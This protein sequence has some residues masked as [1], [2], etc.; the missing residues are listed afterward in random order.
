[1][2][3]QLIVV[4]CIADILLQRYEN[5]RLNMSE[6]NLLHNISIIIALTK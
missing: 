6:N 2:N 3:I 5:N 4:T 1:M